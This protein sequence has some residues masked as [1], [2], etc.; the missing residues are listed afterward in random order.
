MIDRNQVKVILFDMDGTLYQDPD[1]HRP[2]LRYLLQD[3][4]HASFAEES[5][6]LA[7]EI[8][9][10][11]AVPMNRFYRVRR[12][13][14]GFSGWEEM[15]QWMCDSQIPEMPFEDCYRNGIGQL[16]YLGDLWEVAIFIANILGTLPQNG[17]KAFLRV[18]EEMEQT[19]LRPAPELYALLDRLKQRYTTVLLSNSP[20]GTASAFIAR[21]GFDRSFTH[22]FYGAQKPYHLFENLRRHEG[23]EAVRPEKILSIG[24][25]AYNEIA[26][27]RLQGGQTVWINPYADAPQIEASACVRDIPALIETLERALL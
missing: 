3:T 7:D 8:I 5:I 11:D 25:H 27:V 18:R 1:F 24:D 20:E 21:L 12:R 6:R 10:H 22:H 2:Y 23:M 13:E 4:P 17:Q 9:L 16:C 15:A 19:T 14:E 26:P